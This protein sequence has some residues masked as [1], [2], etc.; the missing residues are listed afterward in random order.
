[1]LIGL[2]GYC[3]P[4]VSSKIFSIAEGFTFIFFLAVI[5]VITGFFALV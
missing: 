1:M 4:I 3:V 2:V 5:N